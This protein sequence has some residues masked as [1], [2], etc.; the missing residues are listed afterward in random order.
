[1]AFVKPAPLPPAQPQKLRVPGW[2]F[3]AAEARRRQ[4]A[5]AKEVL[6]SGKRN[7]RWTWAGAYTWT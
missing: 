6:G 4:T 1:M 3:D 7:L 5:A 2:P